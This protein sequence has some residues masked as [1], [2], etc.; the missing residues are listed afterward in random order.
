M[1]NTE[2]GDTWK[3]LLNSLDFLLTK[4]SH[5]EWWL[6]VRVPVFDDLQS[7][8]NG[9][10][11][12][13]LENKIMM[14]QPDSKHLFLLLKRTVVMHIMWSYTWHPTGRCHC[15][16]CSTAFSVKLFDGQRGI[17]DTTVETLHGC[18]HHQGPLHCWNCLQH[19][20]QI[21]HHKCHYKLFSEEKFVI[22][23]LRLPLLDFLLCICLIAVW[24]SAL[25][26]CTVHVIVDIFLCGKILSACWRWHL[27]SR[28]DL[29]SNK[30][31][32][33]SPH[34]INFSDTPVH[35]N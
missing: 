22:G 14:P 4:I 26:H 25:Y 23:D 3:C 24:K 16:T 12:L 1:E 33:V 35:Q 19:H 8:F 28:E 31:S 27:P 17:F 32:Q 6:P 11:G 5:K 30:F 34:L 18:H 21:L 7:F 9:I 15:H 20:S 2:F 10:S 29:N 13:I